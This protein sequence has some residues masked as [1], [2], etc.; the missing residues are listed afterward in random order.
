MHEDFRPGDFT[1]SPGAACMIEM[2][3]SKDNFRNCNFAV[4]AIDLLQ[5]VI[6]ILPSTHVD[7]DRPLISEKVRIAFETS[8]AYRLDVH[9]ENCENAYLSK[10]FPSYKPML[11]IR[12]MAIAD[13]FVHI[14]AFELSDQLLPFFEIHASNGL[15]ERDRFGVH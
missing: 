13:A 1:E 12:S 8:A 7:Q 6:H 10:T 2:C 11:S 4:L 5:Q 15:A 9:F 3:V 14:S